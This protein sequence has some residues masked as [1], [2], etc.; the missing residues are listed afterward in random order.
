MKIKELKIRT[1]N[2]ER[3]I[4]FYSD[5]I[6][7]ELLF[8]SEYEA[9]FLVGKS[10][11]KLVKSKESL[12]YHFAINIP[13]NKEN[14]ALKWLK[15]RVE[16]LRDGKNEIQDFRFWNAKA[17]YFYDLD[18]NIVEFIARRNLKNESQADFDVASLLEISEIGMPVNDIGVAFNKLN[19]ISNLEQFDGGLERFCAIGDENGL[20][21]CINKNKKDWY[22]T[23]D[24]AHSSEF[25]IEFEHNN[26][27]FAV[28]FINGD[29][30]K[31]DKID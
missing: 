7:L 3:Q 25:E 27:E 8:R 14:E 5:K 21:I 4:L 18:K 1:P 30:R 28:K 10:K 15:E 13:F 17:M 19:E 12:P 11:L 9:V 22:P 23:G 16:I 2:L 20:F 6:G 29:L 24:K 31:V 26:R